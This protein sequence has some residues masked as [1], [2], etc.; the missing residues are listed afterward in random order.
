MIKLR[1]RLHRQAGEKVQQDYESL[2][3]FKFLDC[4]TLLLPNM[5]SAHLGF[6]SFP[7]AQ[8]TTT[9]ISS[10]SINVPYRFGNQF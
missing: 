8:P 5:P 6:S 7:T 10:A 9:L 1:P 2:A 3:S 4:S